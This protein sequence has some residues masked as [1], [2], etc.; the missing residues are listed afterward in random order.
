[1][2]KVKDALCS[3]VGG[4]IVAAKTKLNTCPT[5]GGS[6]NFDQIADIVQGKMCGGN[7]VHAAGQDDHH[8]DV[9]TA[10][11]NEVAAAH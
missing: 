2:L 6:L 5:S 10:V 8:N 4:I 1:M 3:C 7:D 11:Q 9:H